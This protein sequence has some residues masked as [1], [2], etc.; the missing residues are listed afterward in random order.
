LEGDVLEA[1]C[2]KKIKKAAG[3]PAAFMNGF[4]PYYF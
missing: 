4:K 3:N 1:G 2:W